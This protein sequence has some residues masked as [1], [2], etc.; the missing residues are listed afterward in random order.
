MHKSQNSTLDAAYYAAV[1]SD[2][3]MGRTRG[4]DYALATYKLDALVLPAGGWT[5]PI[6]G[7]PPP[8]THSPPF[9][10]PLCQRGLGTR[11]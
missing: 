9:L 3:D 11:S 2:Y 4:I 1:A 7:T 6:A 10:T 8:I 5:T